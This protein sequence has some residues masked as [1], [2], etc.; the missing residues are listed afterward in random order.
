[1]QWFLSPYVESWSFLKIFC[2]D[3]SRNWHFF[4]LGIGK[5]AWYFQHNRLI[6]VVKLTRHYYWLAPQQ[7]GC[8]LTNALDVFCFHSKLFLS[9]I[10]CIHTCDKGTSFAI[11]C[12]ENG[13]SNHLLWGEYC[14][15]YHNRINFSVYPITKEMY[16]FVAGVTALS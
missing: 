14:S 1:M 12:T 5:I 7:S 2:R 3:A 11:E 9:G 16:L 13:L 6:S 10:W 15:L 8:Y 4:V